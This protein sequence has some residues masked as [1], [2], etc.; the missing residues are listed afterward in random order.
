MHEIL[1]VFSS[2][3][4]GQALKSEIMRNWVYNLSGCCEVLPGL[5]AVKDKN[6]GELKFHK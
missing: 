4:I 5:E 2:G 1:P 6:L 3:L